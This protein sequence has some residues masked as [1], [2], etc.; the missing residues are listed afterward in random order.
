MFIFYFLLRLCTI[1]N[2]HTCIYTLS[3]LQKQTDSLDNDDIRMLLLVSI[4]TIPT[5]IY[6]TL[7]LLL[8]VN[9][10]LKVRHKIFMLSTKS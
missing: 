6:Q 8:Y 7:I 4:N 1:K 3:L 9:V 10:K 2:M 5:C